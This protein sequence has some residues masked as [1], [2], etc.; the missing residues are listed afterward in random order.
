LIA[1]PTKTTK[2]HDEAGNP[3]VRPDIRI[4]VVDDF[5]KLA[6]PGRRGR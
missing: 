1:L 6:R 5:E 3:R 2:G 4:V